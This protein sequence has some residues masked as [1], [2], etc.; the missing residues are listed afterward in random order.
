[1]MISRGQ[2]KSGGIQAQ[3]TELTERLERQ[4]A[5]N[6][7]LAGSIASANGEIDGLKRKLVISEGQVLELTALSVHRVRTAFCHG[8]GVGVMA[9][10]FV[11]GVVMLLR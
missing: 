7:H 3:L 8:L 6:R 4:Q 2:Q 10:V 11:W 5:D 9:C 1:M